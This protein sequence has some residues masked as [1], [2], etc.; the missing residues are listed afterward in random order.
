MAL[1]KMTTGTAMTIDAST[2][3]VLL[4][5]TFTEY[6]TEKDVYGLAK[7]SLASYKASFAKFKS[8]INEEKYVVGSINIGVIYNWIVTMKEDGQLKHTSIN[9]Y[10]RDIRS[11]LYWCMDKG[12]IS[13]AFRIKLIKGQEELLKTYTDDELKKLLDEPRK[14]NFVE[15]RT[16]VIVNWV[17]GTGNR[18]ST[19]INIQIQDIDFVRREIHLTHTKNKKAQIIPLTPTLGKVLNEY[20]TKYRAFADPTDYLFPKIGNEQLT[21]NALKVSYRK[22]CVARGVEKTS[23]HGLRHSFAKGW[24]MNNGDTFRLQ[25]MLGHS[26]LE[27]TRKY[28][29]IFSD[30][31]KEGFELFNPLE[32]FNKSDNTTQTVRRRK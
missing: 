18:A 23:I 15:H 12:Y 13:P 3:E 16:W 31:L 30:D 5:N 10:L 26:S 6:I 25:K 27:M 17:I 28:V 8:F 32:N 21:T 29:S 24:I 1:K 20:I 14:D 2:V 11:F 22:Y 7:P 19:I 9:H 4:E